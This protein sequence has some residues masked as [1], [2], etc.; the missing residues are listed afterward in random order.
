MRFKVAT[1]L[2]GAFMFL[3]VPAF[4]GSVDLCAGQTANSAHATLSQGGI[5]ATG[6]ASNGVSADL[7]CKVSG[8]PGETG[9]GL[10]TNDS[11]HEISTGNFIQ[12]DVSALSFVTSELTIGSVQTNEGFEVVGSNTSG[13]LGTTVLAGPVTGGNIDNVTV[14][15]KGFQFVDVTATS[16]DVLL[17]SITTPTPEP[18]TYLLLGTGLLMLGFMMRR[19]FVS[20]SC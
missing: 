19:K 15:F 4:A 2:A 20:T 18:S 12:L 10:V 1:L 17:T 14:N 3:T 13:T 16:G 11:T 8:T 5:M 6:W 9:V 7:F